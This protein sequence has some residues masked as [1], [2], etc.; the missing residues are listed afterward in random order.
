MCVAHI[1]AQSTPPHPIAS[2]HDLPIEV[3]GTLDDPFNHQ[4]ILTHDTLVN[5]LD[6]LDS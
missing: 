2:I 5:P 4:G 3:N 1:V 6:F